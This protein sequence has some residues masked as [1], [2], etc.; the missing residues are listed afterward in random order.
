MAS[1]LDKV[2]NEIK[3]IQKV[4]RRAGFT[5]RPMWPM[6]ILPPPK[7]WT[8]PKVVDG[9]PIEGNFR[10]H[11]VPISRP[12]T[13]PEHL[14]ILERWMKSYRPEELFDTK[15]TL[16]KELSELAPIGDKR[17]S[18]NP[19]ANGGLLLQDLR[20]PDFREYGIPVPRP[21]EVIAEPTRIMGSLVRDVMKAN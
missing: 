18:A 14:R 5:T 13:N 11:Q 17:M 9:L 4:A 6:I 20:M 7:G 15:G 16:V 3:R 10:S 12:R 19:H 8:A 1:A 2:I 21:G